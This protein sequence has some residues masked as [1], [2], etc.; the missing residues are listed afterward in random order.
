VVKEDGENVCMTR[1]NSN[2]KKFYHDFVFP[3]WVCEEVEQQL[4]M[5]TIATPKLTVREG[6]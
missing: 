4:V 5:S 6:V 2:Q 1:F 3:F